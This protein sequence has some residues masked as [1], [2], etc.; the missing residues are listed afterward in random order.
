MPSE[1]EV[2]ATLVGPAPDG[3]PSAALEPAPVAG[4]PVVAGYDL[5]RVIGRGGMGVV[6]EAVEHRLDRRV[7]LKVHADTADAEGLGSK[8]VARIWSEARLAAK[9]A[10]PGV[11]AVHD[12]GYTVDGHPYYTMDLVEGTDLRALLREGSLPLA[13]ALTLAL[14]ISR[15]VA[16]AHERGIVHRDLKPANVLVDSRGR[17]R[18]L[19]FGL[20]FQTLGEDLFENR[21]CGTPA[22]M[23]P[24]QVSGGAVGTA[25]DIFAIGVLLYEMLAGVRPFHAG[26]AEATMAAVLSHKP[27]PPS[28]R[29]AAVHADVD[30]VCMRCLEK[31]PQ[32]RFG[33]ARALAT[34]LEEVMEGRPG[35]ASS[36]PVSAPRRRNPPPECA[37]RRS[38]ES[39]PV[40]LHW[41]WQ[42]RSA[43]GALWP[44][45]ANTDRVNKAIGLDPVDFTDTADP[46][47]GSTRIGHLQVLGLDVVWREHPF[48][49]VKGR[50]HSVFREY[51][52]G[53][54]EA[55]WNRVRLEPT[56]DGGTRLEHDIWLEHRNLLGRVA[57]HLEVTRKVGRNLDR[58][59]R[60][61]DDV[62]LKSRG[63]PLDVFEEP[64][65]P[66]EAQKRHVER[67]V[68]ALRDR[69][70]SSGL[71][72]RF[73]A[74]LLHAPDKTLERM[75]PYELADAWGEDRA[76]T[77]ALFLHA[78]HVGLLDIAWDVLCPRCR[79]PH[80]TFG[81]LEGVARAG[82]CVPCGTNYERDLRESVELVFRP[83]REVRAA[84]PATYCAG[85]PALRPH[86]FVQQSL[87][88][89]EKRAVTVDLPRGD[90]RGAASRTPAT[91]DFT[92][93]PAGY[94]DRCDVE[95]GEGVLEVR[96]TVV[97]AGRVTLHFVNL[98]DHE[99]VVRVEVP[100]AREDGVTAAAVMTLPE[101]RDL[102]SR[103]LLAEGEHMSVSRMA[104]LF[105]DVDDR[106][107]V[108]G[109]LGD[110]GAWGV[111]RH[112]EALLGAELRAHG[113]VLVPGPLGVN[114]AAFSASSQ[115]MRAALGLLSAAC[116]AGLVVK[117]RAAVH[118]GQCLAL[119]RGER[120][121]YFGRTLHR[122]VALLTSAPPGDVALSVAVASD[123][124]VVQ[125][126]YELAAPCEVTTERSGPYAG[127]RVTIVR[128]AAR[129]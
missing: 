53:P 54:F 63:E 59:Y 51:R 65:N 112:V 10:D 3:M 9:V 116:A 97:R 43:P 62:V 37:P 28:A 61:I 34:A 80:E 105:V 30:F 117:L 77:L 20:A 71:I 36:A 50:E 83:H 123:R 26:T 79:L 70:F 27:P 31:R 73:Q 42:L 124:A 127:T 7:A 86:V 47:G 67:G 125:L 24:E 107:K 103:E 110:A 85:A 4:G 88:P 119:T 23:A 32:D 68:R 111:E 16:A 18:V 74:C 60:R 21:L 98:T 22:Y 11:V 108:L 12:L 48:E 96:P 118:E 72:D 92:A 76:E 38:P 45:V 41:E 19:D 2:A 93:S 101:F 87:L 128:G 100:G 57:A 52:K 6:W 1:N 90:Y 126:L 17:A 104:F 82:T 75:R 58:L 94:L 129:R 66:T 46:E 114:V 113:G 39:A 122:G 81:G 120:T 15:A 115:A 44:I 14:E 5:V 109:D 56:A 29:N 13:R 25:A 89:G 55:L 8:R 78:A 91:R 69:E 99:Q 84:E 64:H 106:P 49:W 33:S 35:P 102:F 95:V 121:E 40:H